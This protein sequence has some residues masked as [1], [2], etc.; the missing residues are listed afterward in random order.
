MIGA[1]AGVLLG[2]ALCAV[3][4]WVF[5][6]AE[7]ADAVA[8]AIVSACGIAGMGLDVLGRGKRGDE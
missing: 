7:T 5:P 3:L 8:I 6:D 4:Q 2:L 1:T